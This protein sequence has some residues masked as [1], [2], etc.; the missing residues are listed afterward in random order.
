MT[1]RRCRETIYHL[2]R[3][4]GLASA[5]AMG[6]VAGKRCGEAPIGSLAVSK[7]FVGYMLRNDLV[8]VFA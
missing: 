7:R 5:V 4:Q 2:V 3:R 6:S 8:I 1:C